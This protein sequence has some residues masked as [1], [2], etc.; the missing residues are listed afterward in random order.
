M[1]FRIKRTLTDKQLWKAKYLFVM[2]CV[3]VAWQMGTAY[4]AADEYGADPWD[5]DKGE[6]YDALVAKYKKKDEAP[7]DD[8]SYIPPNNF[9]AGADGKDKVNAEFP[10]EYNGGLYKAAQ[11]VTFSRGRIVMYSKNVEICTG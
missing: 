1:K 8:P 6:N 2:S 9:E 5:E 4:M 7:T 10:F 11:A 3:L